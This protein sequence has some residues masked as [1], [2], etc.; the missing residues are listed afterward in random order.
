MENFSIF[1][2]K[3]SEPRLYDAFVNDAF[4]NKALDERVEAEG[5]H[6]KQLLDE[7]DDEIHENGLIQLVTDSDGTHLSTDNL[8]EWLGLYYTIEKK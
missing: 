6:Q 1:L 4:V 7:L 3:Y 5:A 2:K 8:M